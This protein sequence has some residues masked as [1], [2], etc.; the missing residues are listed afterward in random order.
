MG[1]RTDALIKN[2]TE[3]KVG[4]VIGSVETNVNGM[5]NFVRVRVKL[6]VVVPLARFVTV[7]RA[8]Q[9]EFYQVKYEKC[10]NSVELVGWLG[11]FILSVAQE[12]LKKIN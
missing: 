10:Q 11:I 7:S 1:Y 3:R 5:G 9:R 8:S 2:L 12:K 6:H 4:K